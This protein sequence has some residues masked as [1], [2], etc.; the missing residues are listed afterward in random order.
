VVLPFR[1]FTIGLFLRMSSKVTDACTKAAGAVYSRA[2]IQ[3]VYAVMVFLGALVGQRWGIG[4]VAVA[5]SIVMGINWLM[6]AALGRTVTGLSWPRFL[7]AHSPSLL[8]AAL[9]GIAVAITVQA[10]RASHL[11]NLGVLVVAGSTCAAV[12]FMAVRFRPELFL[13]S[14]GAWASR[15]ALATVQGI[16]SRLSRVSN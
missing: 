5:V 3:G 14:H 10:A 16:V 9:M 13:G 6:M 1:L 7:Q 11:G 2:L 15:Q 8:F 4:G 12:T